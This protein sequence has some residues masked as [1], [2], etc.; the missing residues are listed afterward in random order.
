M[1]MT[2]AEQDRDLEDARSY[3]GCTSMTADRCR[4]AATDHTAL[5]FFAMIGAGKRTTRTQIGA[6]SRLDC[7]DSA[8]RIYRWEVHRMAGGVPV[9]RCYASSLLEAVTF[10]VRYDYAGA[11]RL[12]QAMEA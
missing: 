7:Q 9:A 12:R 11:S 5:W 1:S 3:L 4:H 2:Q 8:G 10:I 6:A